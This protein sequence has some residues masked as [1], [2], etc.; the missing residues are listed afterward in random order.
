MQTEHYCTRRAQGPPTDAPEEA[1]EVDPAAEFAS[2]LAG[3]S[4][5]CSAAIYDKVGWP[6]AAQ[7]VR[8]HG[9]L[10]KGSL[11]EAWVRANCGDKFTLATSEEEGKEKTPIMGNAR[12]LELSTLLGGCLVWGSRAARR[13]T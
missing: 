1:A 9:V 3:A 12:F 5:Q 13:R 11:G 10:G 2:H 8:L 4:S 7:T 6:L